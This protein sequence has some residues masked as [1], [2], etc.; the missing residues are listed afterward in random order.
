MIGI[1]ATCGCMGI[2]HDILLQALQLNTHACGATSA[3]Y[4]SGYIVAGYLYD[5]SKVPQV[6][7]VVGLGGGG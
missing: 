6:E 7:C 3:A 2:M 1:S 5:P 4:I